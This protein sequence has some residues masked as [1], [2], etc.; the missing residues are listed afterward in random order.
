M[1]AHGIEPNLIELKIGE[2]G[3]M[4]DP[5]HAIR[6]MNELRAAGF[7]V[8]IDDFGTGHLSLPYLARFPVSALKIGR[9]FVENLLEDQGDA[10]IVR[11]IFDLARAFRCAVVAEGVET[12]GQTEYLKKLLR[13]EAQG[14]YLGRPTDLEAFTV[15]LASVNGNP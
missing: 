2:S 10:T 6:M 4:K 5:D 12:S 9:P 15:L 3:V 14:F 7:H 13:N 11:A 1:N 8:V